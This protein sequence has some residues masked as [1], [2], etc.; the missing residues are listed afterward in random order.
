MR[1]FNVWA[2]RTRRRMD[3]PFFWIE[4][5][6]PLQWLLLAVAVVAF[7]VLSVAMPEVCR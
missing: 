3:V 5:R 1:R 4:N 2:V 7:V 6:R